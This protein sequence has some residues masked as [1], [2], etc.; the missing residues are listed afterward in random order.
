MK[1]LADLKGVLVEEPEY[2]GEA[3]FSREAR[4]QFPEL[5][6]ELSESSGL[7][8]VQIGGLA[9]SARR[10]FEAEDSAFLRR[11]F[12]FLEDV[13]SR[14]RLWPEIEN[15]LTTSFLFPVDFEKSRIGRDMWETLPER[16]KQVLLKAA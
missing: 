12:L 16:L 13:L 7:I 10:A 6:A 1:P 5:E 4:A 8:H 9:E 2:Y 14:D 11:L 3:S 15:A